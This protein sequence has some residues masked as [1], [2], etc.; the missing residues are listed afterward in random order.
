MSD[1]SFD[2]A[3]HALTLGYEKLVQAAKRFGENRP[4]DTENPY[5]AEIEKR[6]PH[7]TIHIQV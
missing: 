2:H 3:A 5:Q 6:F 4:Q 7:R 1:T